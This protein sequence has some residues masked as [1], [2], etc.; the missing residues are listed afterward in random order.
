MGGRKNGGREG[1]EFFFFIHSPSSPFL[2]LFLFLSLFLSL[3]F[4]LPQ[5]SH[6]AVSAIMSGVQMYEVRASA[7]QQRRPRQ[8]RRMFFSFFFLPRRFLLLTLFSSSSHSLPLSLPPLLSP[9]GLQSSVLGIPM[10]RWLRQTPPYT[11][12]WTMVA[13]SAAAAIGCIPLVVLSFGTSVFYQ[14]TSRAAASGA[15]FASLLCFVFSMQISNLIASFVFQ[16]FVDRNRVATTSGFSTSLQAAGRGVGV[17]A[18]GVIFALSGANDGDEGNPVPGF[19]G[20]VALACAVLLSA[21]A[22]AAF[23]YSKDF[24]EGG[25]NCGPCFSSQQKGKGA[26]GGGGEGGGGASGYSAAATT[27]SGKGLPSSDVAL[28]ARPGSAMKGA[29]K[30]ETEAAT[31]A[32]APAVPK[33]DAAAAA[34]GGDDDVEK[35]VVSKEK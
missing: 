18:S 7:T 27:T 8:R 2:F 25:F 20:S 6:L 13:W 34:A 24:G 28:A 30:G 32:A 15:F 10:L 9:Q 35:A 26:A 3:S 5:M 19:G 33:A 1:G 16:H 31:A 22:I 21:A 4:S 12:K 17:L 11:N 14:P 23:G 29:I